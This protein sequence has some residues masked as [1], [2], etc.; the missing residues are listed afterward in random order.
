MRTQVDTTG[1][2]TIP[3]RYEELLTVKQQLL[4]SD[5]LSEREKHACT[6]QSSEQTSNGEASKKRF[7]QTT[8]NTQLLEPISY[9]TS[10]S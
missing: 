5:S 8:K 6:Q 1:G 2:A 3:A 4:K 9:V 10:I 7:S